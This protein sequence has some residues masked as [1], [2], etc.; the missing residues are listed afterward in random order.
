L[1]G[2]GEIEGGK[3]EFHPVR[4]NF[5]IPRIDWAGPVAESLICTLLD[6]HLEM[7]RIGNRKEMVRIYLFL[8]W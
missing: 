6:G 2:R 8:K 1:T 4:F 7:E 3:K 5:K